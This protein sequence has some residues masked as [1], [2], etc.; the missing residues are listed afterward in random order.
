MAEVEAQTAHAC[1]AVSPD[2]FPRNKKFKIV[3]GLKD[4]AID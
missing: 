1:N 4:R 2:Q 3:V